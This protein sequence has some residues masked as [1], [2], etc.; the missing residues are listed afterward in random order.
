MRG[1]DAANSLIDIN[2]ATVSELKKHPGIGAALA[3]NIVASGPYGSKAQQVTK[4]ILDPGM[5]ESL[6]RQLIA[7]QSNEIAANSASEK[8]PNQ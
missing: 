2:S 4:N 5:C 3:A 6:S 1:P 8:P 7:K